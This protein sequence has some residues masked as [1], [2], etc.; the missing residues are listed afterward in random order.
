MERRSP[1]RSANAA[2]DSPFIGVAPPRSPA[3][4]SAT[5]D[6][7]WLMARTL[8]DRAGREAPDGDPLRSRRE[9]DTTTLV[10]HWTTGSKVAHLGA[11]C[12]SRRG[13]VAEPAGRFRSLI[14]GVGVR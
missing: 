3:W 8:L 1:W 6:S 13:Q 9:T 12:G 14:S 5:A 2:S 4:A 7:G 11:G 10:G